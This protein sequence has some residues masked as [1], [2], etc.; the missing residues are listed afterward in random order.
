M[1]ATEGSTCKPVRITPVANDIGGYKENVIKR[2][3]PAI[4]GT[5]NSDRFPVEYI[6]PLPPCPY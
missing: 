4:L 5:P 6:I 2:P 1:C 3:G